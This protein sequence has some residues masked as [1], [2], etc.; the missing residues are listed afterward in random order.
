MMPLLDVFKW[1]K[2]S[3]LTHQQKSQTMF[4]FNNQIKNTKNIFSGFFLYEL[5]IYLGFCIIIY[6]SCVESWSVKVWILSVRKLCK[7]FDL[8]YLNK[9]KS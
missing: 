3:I 9:K 8:S 1:K 5:W 7:T 2:K 6:S 4:N